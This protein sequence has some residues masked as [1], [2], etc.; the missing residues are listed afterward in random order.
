MSRRAV[1]VED[2]EV[3]ARA[4][5]SVLGL[6][7]FE[8]VRVVTDPR[9]ALDVIRGFDPDLIVLDIAM[10]HMTGVEVIGALAKRPGQRPGLMVFS[11]TP[12]ED[13]DREL[14][15]T[16]FGYDTF[17]QKPATL[18]ELRTGVRVALEATRPRLTPD[19]E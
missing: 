1:V 8:D 6:E 18:Q 11:A 12:R 13:L 4:V 17:L 2:V 16:G 3:V 7:G 15:G 5:S 14:H 10:P 9:Q 19:P